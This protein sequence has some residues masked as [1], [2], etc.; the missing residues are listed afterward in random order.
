[1]PA[2]ASSPAAEALA[3]QALGFIAADP[4]LLPRFLALTGIEADAIRRAAAEPG[5]LAGVLNFLLAH[6]PTLTAFCQA[7]DID[8]AAVGQAQRALPGG[9]DDFLAST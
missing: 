3:I 2:S 5:F 1:M 4:V 9:N 8:P 7:H 6:E